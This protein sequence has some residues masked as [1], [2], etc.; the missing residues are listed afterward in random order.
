MGITALRGT[1]ID[2]DPIRRDQK[3]CLPASDAFCHH[4]CGRSSAFGGTCHGTL[5]FLWEESARSTKPEQLS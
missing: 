4:F 1:Q 2:A 5:L 3:H